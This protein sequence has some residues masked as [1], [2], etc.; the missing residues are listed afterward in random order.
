[1]LM[2]ILNARPHA[3]PR[4]LPHRM[5]VVETKHPVTMRIV[6]RSE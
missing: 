4:S 5:G 6:Q 3:W 2:V 1:M